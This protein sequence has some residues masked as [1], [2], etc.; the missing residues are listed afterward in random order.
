MLR[1]RTVKGRVQPVK[2]VLQ[3]GKCIPEGH[4]NVALAT[5]VFVT[6]A[7]NSRTSK[8]IVSCS[9]LDTMP[10]S[11]TFVKDYGTGIQLSHAVFGRGAQ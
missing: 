6:G 8:V 1:R 3:R 10:Y 11:D 7:L 4:M 5:S 9:G 2:V